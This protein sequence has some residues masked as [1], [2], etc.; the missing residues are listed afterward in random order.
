MNIFIRYL[1]HFFNTSIV[2]LIIFLIVP[3]IGC[4]VYCCQANLT[5]QTVQQ[6]IENLE[7]YQLV[8]E[9]KP[10]YFYRIQSEAPPPYSSLF[11]S[12][13]TITAHHASYNDD[14]TRVEI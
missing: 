10:H 9:P 14:L 7:P 8:N 4:I 3:I 13:T 11:Q 6:R 5:Q 2:P 12:Q 1:I